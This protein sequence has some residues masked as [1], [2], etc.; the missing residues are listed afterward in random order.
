MSKCVPLNNNTLLRSVNIPM[1]TR[2]WQLK[3]KHV[4]RDLSARI[5][6]YDYHVVKICKLNRDRKKTL[7]NLTLIYDLHIKTPPL[8][9]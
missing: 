3:Y 5:V 7:K 1:E 6:Q 8:S 4:N 2:N 9:I